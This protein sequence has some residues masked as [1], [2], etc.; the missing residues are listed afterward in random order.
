MPSIALYRREITQDRKRRGQLR[1]TLEASEPLRV[2]ASAAESGRF[3]HL[4]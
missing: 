4:V 1:R 3:V 2:R